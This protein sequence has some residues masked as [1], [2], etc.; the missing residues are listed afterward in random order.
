MRVVIVEMNGVEQAMD[1]VVPAVAAVPSSPTRAF[2][3]VFRADHRSIVALAWALTGDRAVAE[4]VTQEAFLR[5]HQR[6]GRI[7]GYDNP[8]AWVRRTAINLALSDRRRRGA[9]RRALERVGP[10][11]ESS[12]DGAG[13]VA[14]ADRFWRAVRALPRRQ[15]AVV[16]LHYVEDRSV[17]E[18]ATVLEIAEGTVK[19]HLHQARA[20]LSASFA[21]EEER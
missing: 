1:P 3:A 5:A 7:G 13:A 2:E 14:S 17:A 4:E 21:P 6:W 18:I 10:P 15:A 12:D 9:E 16:A 11:A 8:G 19:A 20:A